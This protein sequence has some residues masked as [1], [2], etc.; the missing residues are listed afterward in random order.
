MISGRGSGG[1][2]TGLKCGVGSLSWLGDCS[3]SCQGG[4]VS[5]GDLG[6]DLA[7]PPSSGVAF[8]GTTH[9][10][11]SYCSRCSLMRGTPIW[12]LSWTSHLS[13]SEKIGRRKKLA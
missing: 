12:V 2:V 4:I 6:A 11:Q 8:G 5:G 1:G 9:A 3:F 13:F 10:F 7:A